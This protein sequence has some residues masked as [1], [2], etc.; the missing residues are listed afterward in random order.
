MLLTE[1]TLRVP[2]HRMTV[3]KP[4]TCGGILPIS[5]P[6]DSLLYSYKEGD[7]HIPM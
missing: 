5:K 6:E 3:E 7:V 4:H 1:V 2:K